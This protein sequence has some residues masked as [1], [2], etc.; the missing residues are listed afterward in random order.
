MIFNKRK[1]E[2][3]LRQ[4]REL[5]QKLIDEEK[6][7]KEEQLRLEAERQAKEEAEKA[8]KVLPYKFSEPSPMPK[9]LVSVLKDMFKRLFPDVRKAYLVLAEYEGKKGYLLVVD[10]DAKFLKIINIYLD[11]ETKKVR[12]GYPIEC[13]LFSGSGNLTE[14]MTPFY[15]KEVP[16]S[17]KVKH[18]SDLPSFGDLPELAIDA[19]TIESINYEF[20]ATHV[21]EAPVE[22]TPVEET[23]VEEA[24]VEDAPVEE[25]PVEE[26]PVE[27][28]PV[29]EAL[30]ED[31]PVEDA[32]VEEASVEEAPVEETPV[33]E[34]PV[35]E[36]LVEEAPVDDIPTLEIEPQSVKVEPETKQQLFALM[37]RAGSSDS[38][39][40]ISVARSGFSEYR[41]FIP[42]NSD[43][44][45]V[46]ENEKFGKN[47]R[48]VL[49]INRDSG[50][51]AIAFFTDFDE[52]QTFAQEKGH[53]FVAVKYKDYKEAVEEGIVVA[54]SAEGIIINPTNEKI[55]LAPDYPLL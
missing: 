29:E 45:A 16:E 40:V 41:F 37:N 14:G 48:P 35:E 49:L 5:A 24:P 38:E 32:P 33:E 25:T 51:K 8:A 26:T 22:E 6:L 15:Q 20:G 23:P 36:A 39:D 3:E 12:N 4:Q 30:V 11:G 31:A 47:S 53:S 13:I 17:A 19:K 55:L 2:E 10:I 50:I 52:A 54:A 46:G 18:R 7:R 9:E 27:E 44:C 21:E 43:D 1:K 34:A 28:A 42:F